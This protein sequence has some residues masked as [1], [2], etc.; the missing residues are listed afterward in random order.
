MISLLFYLIIFFAIAI[1]CFYCVCFIIKLWTGC[2]TNEA[3]KKIHRFCTGT[4]QQQ[5]YA[6]A[7]FSDEIWANIRNIIGDKR[8]QQLK[9]LSNTAISVPL[10]SYGMNGGLPYIAVSVFCL[11]NNEKQILE[12]VLTN[13]VKRYLD[14]YGYETDI[15]PNWKIRCDLNM[16]VLEIR[17]ARTQG[18][19]RALG[20]YKQIY[21]KKI[22]QQYEPVTDDTDCEDLNDETN[23]FRV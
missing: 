5:L 10:L 2:T 3:I 13:I 22:V 21:Q 9:N 6:D 20:I 19:K 11:D 7:G 18:E 14:M 16:P 4:A 17:Y 12:T 1:L 23:I 15:L 8:F